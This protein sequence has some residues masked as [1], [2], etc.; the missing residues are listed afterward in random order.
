[1]ESVATSAVLADDGRMAAG[2]P[3]DAT[4]GGSDYGHGG[5]GYEHDG[6]G[7]D[8]QPDDS[9]LAAAGAEAAFNECMAAVDAAVD[10]EEAA[11][12]ASEGTV[13]EANSEGGWSPD[14][15]VEPMVSEYEIQRLRA[16][17]ANERGLLNLNLI[18]HTQVS[19]SSTRHNCPPATSP[20][21]HAPNGV[22]KTPE[23]AISRKNHFLLWRLPHSAKTGKVHYPVWPSEKQY[24]TYAKSYLQYIRLI[25]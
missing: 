15:L 4:A 16:I 14:W 20:T 11:R 5:W 22:C 24:F 23:G 7:S 21:S 6:W 9:D 18:P 25:H 1:M 10:A 17:V 19:R 8:F 3:A 2:A 13:V 12:A